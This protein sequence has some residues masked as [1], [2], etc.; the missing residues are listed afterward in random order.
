MIHGAKVALRPLTCDDI[1]KISSWDSDKEIEALAGW[2]SKGH[3]AHQKWYDTMVAGRNSKIFGIWTEDGEMIGDIGLSGISW[4]GGE[5]ELVVRIGEKEYWNQGYG[6]DAVSAL[7]KYAFSKLKLR[8]VYLRVYQD[9]VRAV[10]CYESCGFVK[11]GV[12]S[13]RFDEGPKKIYLMTITREGGK[14][15][16]SASRKAS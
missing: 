13:R 16:R 12:V 8:R 14:R 9:N 3:L 10:R 15:G 1:E 7:V 2:D 5:A 11:E 6:R 4:R